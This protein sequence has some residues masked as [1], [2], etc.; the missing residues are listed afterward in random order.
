MK[1][2]LMLR[3]L[4]TQPGGIGTYTA[5]L[6]PRLLELDRTNDYFLLY[7][8]EACRGSYSAYP[9]VT[10]IVI[11]GSSK[12]AWDQVAVPKAASQYGLD[13]VF[14]PKLSIPLCA[15]CRTVFV[16]HGADW[17]VFPQNYEPLDRL[18]HCVVAPIYVR[19]ADAVIS[20]SEDATRRILESLRMKREK[21]ATIHSAVG[22]RFR[23]IHD[24][25]RLAAVR[26]KYDLPERFLL[27]VGQI[28]PMKN[29]GGIIKAYA[30][31]REVIPHKLVIVGR[32][33]RRSKSE[34]ALIDRYGLR[35]DVM[36]TGYVPDA[37]IPV[38]YNLAELFVFPS[39]YEGFGLPL[40]EA[41]ACG[42][43]IVT[44]AGGAT[45][46]VAGDAARLVNPRD[47]ASIAEGID[48]L[49]HDPAARSELV[50]RGLQR[51][52]RFTWERCAREVLQVL[53]SVGG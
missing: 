1:I 44:S 11:P 3:H 5:S 10:E 34:L 13:L 26:K 39:L 32:P 33:T 23:P 24:P 14:N 47:P 36:V 50:E 28:Y 4:R 29:V 22:E 31:L 17:F 37:E 18:Y 35:G 8:D 9:N 16:L 7:R 48:D 12:L 42:C 46:E 53:H 20:V 19:R 27:Y 6:V 15:K 2:G 21:I 30:R 40:L 38:F 41:M 25:E 45:E 52:Q 49:L 43:P 51:A